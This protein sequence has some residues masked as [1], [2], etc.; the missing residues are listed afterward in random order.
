MKNY[1][2]LKQAIGWFK[3]ML[4]LLLVVAGTVAFAQERSISG[5]VTDKSTNE[6]LPGASVLI[7]GTS[8]GSITDIDGKFAFQ[9]PTG[10]NVLVISYIG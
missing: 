10:D 6:T 1:L 8:I 2:P 3:S 5:T 7:K 4:M 9:V